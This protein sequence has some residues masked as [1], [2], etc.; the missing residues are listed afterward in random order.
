MCA[1]NSSWIFQLKTSLKNLRFIFN[2]KKTQVL[3]EERDVLR[4]NDTVEEVTQCLQ[5]LESIREEFESKNSTIKSLLKS[6]KEKLPTLKFR[7]MRLSSYMNRQQT[8]KN[9]KIYFDSSRK[10][11]TLSEFKMT[12]LF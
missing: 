1:P 2:E 12:L 5:N 3:V 8:E 7:Q 10:I 9:L 4:G 6:I 11:L